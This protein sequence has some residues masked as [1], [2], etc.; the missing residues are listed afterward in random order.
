ML[1]HSPI[2]ADHDATV[3][4][5]PAA[6]VPAD[7]YD[8]TPVAIDMPIEVVPRRSQGPRS[9]L[10]GRLITSPIVLSHAHLSPAYQ[11]YLAAFSCVTEPKTYKEA[12]SNPKWIKAMQEEILA[13]EDNHTWKLV[14]LPPGKH[15]I[16]CKWV[17]KASRQ[18]NV[19]LID[20]LVASG[21]IQSKLDHSLFIRRHNEKIV[22]ILVYVDDMMIAGNDLKLIEQTK[23]ELHA[24]FKIK[25][26]GTLK[27]F[28]GIEF[29][30]SNKGI[31]INQRKY[32]LEMI[33]EAG[34]TGAKP[35]WTP[36]DNNIR[37]TTREMDEIAG[38][39]DD[40]A[41]ED[42]GSYQRLIGRLLYLTLTLTRLDIC[43]AV[44][45][46][47]QFLQALKRF[48]ME[49][50]LRVVR[51]I[52]RQPAMGILMSSRKQNRPTAY[53]DA[54][55]AACPNTRRSVTGFLVKHGD[56]LISWKSKKQT[57]IS[58]SSAESEY[59][60]MASAVSEIVWITG[61]YKEL[62]KD[63][64][65]LVE[66]YCDSKAALQIAA[67]PISNVGTNIRK[68]TTDYTAEEYAGLFATNLESAYHL[69]QLAHPLLR[70]SGNGSVV[71][72]SSVAG[73]VHISSGSIYGATKGAMNQLT[74]NLACEWAKDS[75][76]V[77]GVAPW[78]IRTSLI[79]DIDIERL[80][81]AKHFFGFTEAQG[82][83]AVQTALQ[84]EQMS[85]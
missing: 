64:E 37:L 19:K 80:P 71:F 47:S 8:T 10:L 67:N 55:W 29:S 66:L 24:K 74:R 32:A 20:A 48:P 68:P 21:F 53:C 15:P 61:L 12:C 43:F 62:G 56:S 31:L 70:A 76:R 17:Y 45:T 58:R 81:E 5:L 36:L 28:L 33:E 1:L 44:Q 83:D 6:L 42:M 65:L 9:N 11:H 77:N 3:D 22:V 39:K 41:L 73:L 52:K 7:T 60:S 69:C 57:T 13:L 40:P 30:R 14:P 72:I 23:K 82:V 75:I 26:L 85:F 4:H 78:Y 54:D 84:A 35:S 46:L 27:Y 63:L 16:G 59:R 38:V 2:E 79:R 34:L 50:A 49:V 25:D 18:W 51:Y